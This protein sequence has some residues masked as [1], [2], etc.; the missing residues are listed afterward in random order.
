[1][2]FGRAVGHLPLNHP[3][4]QRVVW[5]I[6]EHF[7]PKSG[8]LDIRM[9]GCRYPGRDNDLIDMLA[10]YYGAFE[11]PV[12]AL[13]RDLAR[14]LRPLGRGPVLYDI[15]ANT[16]NHSLFLARE[17]C[18]IYAFEPYG[19]VRREF[20]RR[21]GLNGIANIE[22]FPFA[23]GDEEGDA[24]YY[25]PVTWNRG[26]GS[27]IGGA[28]YE[29]SRYPLRLPVVV[30]DR[31]VEARQ[32]R[33][34]DLIKLDV[35]GTEK[36]VLTGLAETIARHRPIIVAELSRAGRWMFGGEPGLRAKLYEDCLLLDVS[37]R[38][39]LRGYHFEPFDFA[40][41]EQFLCVPCERLSLLRLPP[42]LLARLH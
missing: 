16:G 30:G 1:M 23:L 20:E 38:T 32:L 37:P 5:F 25:P 12:V 2:E 13:L 14:R 19:A 8:R 4:Q 39:P 9:A 27:F 18:Q 40:R 11:W 7:K 28:T 17:V 10:Y 26:T 29:N 34:P 35:E 41:S 3:L 42:R 22:L 15:G 36:L 24:N 33:P 21:I 6:H 31:F